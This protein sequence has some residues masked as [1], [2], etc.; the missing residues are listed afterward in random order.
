MWISSP[1]AAGRQVQFP[2]M[3]FATT[4]FKESLVL[5]LL[6]RLG[7]PQRHG[8]HER[9]Q[10]HDA[11]NFHVVVRGPLPASLVNAFVV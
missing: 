1:S 7:D 9:L 10:T 3:Q 11:P 5:A 2:S 8:T 6:V 4:M